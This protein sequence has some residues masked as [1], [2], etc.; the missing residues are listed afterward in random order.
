MCELDE[1]SP[2]LMFLPHPLTSVVHLASCGSQTNMISTEPS[3]SLD[4]WS[5]TERVFF[6]LLHIWEYLAWNLSLHPTSLSSNPS[7]FANPSA[8]LYGEVEVVL[9]FLLLISSGSRCLRTGMVFQ[10][11]LHSKCEVS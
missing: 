4:V 7:R 11:S 9:S 3:S 6:C 2:D 8:C 10:P 1:S 5:G